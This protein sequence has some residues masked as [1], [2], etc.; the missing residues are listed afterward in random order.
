MKGWLHECADESV[1]PW[2]GQCTDL[3]GVPAF[4]PLSATAACIVLGKS[5]SVLYPW[6]LGKLH[7]RRE[8]FLRYGFL[9]VQNLG[10]GRLGVAGV[11]LPSHNIAV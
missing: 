4:S 10:N 11:L 1:C 8:F 6:F 2:V 3:Q 5:L 9:V 7:E